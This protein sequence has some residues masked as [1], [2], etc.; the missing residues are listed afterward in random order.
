M[1][2]VLGEVA[3]G[4]PVVADRPLGWRRDRLGERVKTEEED[5]ETHDGQEFSSDSD[6]AFL[7]AERRVPRTE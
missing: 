6:A 5:K 4:T 2:F 7:F 1:A 3:G